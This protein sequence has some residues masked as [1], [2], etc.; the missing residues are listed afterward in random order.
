MVVHS[1]PV[2][3]A[4]IASLTPSI[5]RLIPSERRATVLSAVSAARTLSVALVYPAVGAILDRS[6]VAALVGLGVLGLLA[7]AF[8]RA[9]ARLFEEPPG[10][11]A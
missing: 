10:T 9:P 7:A 6:L 1:N 8:A 5:N 2:R 11:S 3:L 4:D